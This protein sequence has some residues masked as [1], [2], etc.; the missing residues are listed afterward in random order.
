M[1]GWGTGDWL[2]L[3]RVR[4]W[5]CGVGGLGGWEVVVGCIPQE[6][7]PSLSSH[8]ISSLFS[9]FDFSSFTSSSSRLCYLEL[10]A[11]SLLA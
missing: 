8:L 4:V 2:R 5:G 1:G 9:F 6:P 10:F 11:D 3:M 7:P